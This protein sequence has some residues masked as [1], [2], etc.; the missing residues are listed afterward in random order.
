MAKAKGI[1]TAGVLFELTLG[2]SLSLLSFLLSN[3]MATNI[4]QRP[5]IAP[6][7]QI[8]SFNI[9][10]DA[11]LTAT[12][13]IFTGYER[14]ELHSIT[15]ILQSSLKATLSLLLVIF[16]LGVF[17]AVIGNTIAALTSGLLSTSML[18]IVIYKNTE[19]IAKE[20]LRIIENIKTM[21]KYGLPISISAILNGLLAQ[22]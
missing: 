9:L 18:Y 1:L 4:L 20:K 16:G 8:A 14:M 7:I 10:A 11:L 5:D 13:S 2:L 22:I 19:K 21:F 12:N 17:G 6:L 3:F 15:L